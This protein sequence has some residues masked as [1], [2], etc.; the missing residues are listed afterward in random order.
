[1]LFLYNQERIG[2]IDLMT[3]LFRAC[4]DTGHLYHQVA[5]QI[6]ASWMASSNSSGA[7]FKKKVLDDYVASCKTDLSAHL[8][9]YPDRAAA[10]TRQNLLEQKVGGVY[11][12]VIMRMCLTIPFFLAL[13][14]T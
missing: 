5:K 4:Q 1:M 14:S 7:G 3:A 2:T 8:E 9:N 11:T 6:T 12:I 10:W 13:G